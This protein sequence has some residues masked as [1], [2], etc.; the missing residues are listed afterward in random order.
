MMLHHI[1]EGAVS[2]LL[3][4]CGGVAHYGRQRHV[5][6]SLFLL[7]SEAAASCAD[8]RKGAMH[9]HDLLLIVRNT[10]IGHQRR[11]APQGSGAR[12]GRVVIVLNPS[13]EAAAAL[14]T[15]VANVTAAPLS[16]VSSAAAT[17][18]STA[19][20]LSNGRACIPTAAATATAATTATTA[21]IPTAATA[22]ATAVAT[23]IEPRV[24]GDLLQGQALC[25]VMVEHA[26]EKVGQLRVKHMT[27]VRM[28]VVPEARLSVLQ[29]KE[30]V[31]AG[32]LRIT[33][34]MILPSAW[35][36]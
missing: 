27:P 24:V 26:V 3:R 30:A 32:E 36:E 16:A 4:G 31:V 8:C 13:E 9:K 11:A 12:D 20:I 21:A 2:L 1:G 17:A 7:P 25:R 23:R 28:M 22:V 6:V 34:H 14:T 19:T 29:R 18:G 10:R 35:Q 15:I 33:Q 5:V